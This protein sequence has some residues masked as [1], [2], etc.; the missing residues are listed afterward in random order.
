VSH[1]L[2]I[3]GCVIWRHWKAAST[4][5]RAHRVCIE[6]DGRAPD[7][8]QLW[9]CSVCNLSVRVPSEPLD[10]CCWR[11]MKLCWHGCFEVMLNTIRKISSFVDDRPESVGHK[12]IVVLNVGDLN[13]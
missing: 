11:L 2:T 3:D 1:Q 9:P 5:K 7:W 8:S 12:L 10:H 6:L 4:V 13:P